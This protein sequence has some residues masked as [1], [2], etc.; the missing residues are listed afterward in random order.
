MGTNTPRVIEP[1]LIELD[2]PRKLLF[3]FAGMAWAEQELA[4]FWGL[5]RISLLK[6]MRE[7]EI[8]IGELACILCGG[9]K[10][11]QP[12]L[13]TA[14]VLKMLEQSNLADAYRQ[15]DEALTKQW[16]VTKKPA[17]KEGAGT[18]PD[19]PS[20]STGSPSGPSGATTSD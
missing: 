9:L 14:D 8:G 12:Q 19:P 1:V 7:G 3:N 5:K 20:S 2:E 18:Q 6:V 15:L 10:H 16:G 11:E 4:R 13:T 17:G